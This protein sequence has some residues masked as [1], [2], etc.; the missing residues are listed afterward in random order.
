MPLPIRKKGGVWKKN[1]WFAP[2]KAPVWGPPCLLTIVKLDEA[3]KRRPT[4]TGFIGN[5]WKPRLSQTGGSLI[6][7]FCPFAAQMG[8]NPLWLV[9]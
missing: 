1:V 7:K 8:F 4:V 6:G 2:K 5:C 3:K 9:V